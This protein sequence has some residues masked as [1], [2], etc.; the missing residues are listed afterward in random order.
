MNIKCVFGM[1]CNDNLLLNHYVIN[2]TQLCSFLLEFS[3]SRSFK[4]KID[5]LLNQL[6]LV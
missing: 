1:K 6:S 3:I 4:S 5:F 2:L